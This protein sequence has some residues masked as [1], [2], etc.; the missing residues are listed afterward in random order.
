MNLGRRKSPRSSGQDNPENKKDNGNSIDINFNDKDHSE[1]EGLEIDEMDN[2]DPDGKVDFGLGFKEKSGE[3][4]NESL[5]DV[6]QNQD[7]DDIKN[8]YNNS[9][10][11]DD[12]QPDIEAQVQLEYYENRSYFFIFGPPTTGKTALIMSLY[13]YLKTQRVGDSFRSINDPNKPAEHIGNK[14]IKQFDQYVNTKVF[15]PGNVAVSNAEL[16]IPRLISFSFQPNQNSKKPRMDFCFLD[17]AGEDLTK[18]DAE[19]RSPLPSSIRTFIEDLPK[20]NLRII[21][22]IDPVEEYFKKEEQIQL[23]NAFINRIDIEEHTNTPILFLVTKWDTI[24][25]E[26]NSAKNYLENEYPEIWS[27]L[28]DE[29]RNADYGKFSIGQVDEST[30]SIVDF[31]YSFPKN[32]F[33]WIY[34]QHT[35]VELDSPA[36]K[37]NWFTKFLK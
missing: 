5:D 21:Y 8:E 2:N 24:E 30:N 31:D 33:K 3:D 37:G 32:V 27:T 35:G 16:N 34:K 6:S 28:H 4:S 20:S 1:T 12:D 9:S 22:L 15:P 19:S 14:A 10:E 18:Y 26:Y 7:T 25:N 36:K 11:K 23:F 13:R 29:N 17:I